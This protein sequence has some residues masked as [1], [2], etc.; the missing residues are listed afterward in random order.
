HID[1]FPNLRVNSRQF[2]VG[3]GTNLRFTT[4]STPIPATP[5]VA[6]QQSTATPPTSASPDHQRLEDH[7]RAQDETPEEPNFLRSAL[8]ALAHILNPEGAA[9]YERDVERPQQERERDQRESLQQQQGE[10]PHEPSPAQFAR[11]SSEPAAAAASVLGQHTHA[12]G[13]P[14]VTIFT[15]PLL[16]PRD[17][18]SPQAAT[19]VVHDFEE[20]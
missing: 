10:A 12:A 16:H 18:N 13:A 7:P 14:R 9:A 20:L 5:Y 3:N 8:N 15:R 19:P 6:P 1:G 4:L 2:V 11:S 17:A